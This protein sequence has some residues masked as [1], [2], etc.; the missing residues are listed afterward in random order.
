V[1]V[2]TSPPCG[3]E[4]L[5]DEREVN[6]A[7]GA[8]EHCGLGPCGQELNVDGG[9]LLACRCLGNRSAKMRSDPVELQASE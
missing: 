4:S 2:P 3:L 9:R 8:L 5:G 1:G 6:N 7:S